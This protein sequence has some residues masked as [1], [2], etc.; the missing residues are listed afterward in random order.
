M[1]TGLQVE[2]WGGRSGCRAGRRGGQWRNLGRRHL[3]RYRCG[4]E[5]TTVT[6]ETSLDRD[7][8]TLPAT[9]TTENHR[10]TAHGTAKQPGGI[11][12]DLCELSLVLLPTVL[13]RLEKR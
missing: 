2:R 9:S 11:V 8:A 13:L 1:P 7:F 6:G 10:T 5:D 4:E 12:A 3:A